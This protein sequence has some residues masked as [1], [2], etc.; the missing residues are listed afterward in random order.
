MSRT[1]NVDPITIDAADMRRL[2]LGLK[3]LAPKVRTRVRREIRQTGLQ[4]INEQKAILDGPLPAGVVKTGRALTTVRNPKT[5]KLRWAARNVYKDRDV[6]RGGRSTNLRADIKKGLKLRIV[7]G[8]TRQGIEFRTGGPKRE[9][10]N[11]AGVWNN[12]RF[13][14]PVFG[15]R[16]NWV[17]Q[18]GQ[19]FFHG[20]IY[21]GRN[22]VLGEI[23]AILK[24]EIEGI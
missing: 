24:R 6:K 4:V 2:L 20:P 12:K 9:G 23:E 3:D 7:I 18:H 11:M 8:K 14:H 19:P 10:S 16:D 17:D 21:R 5:G 1:R 22:K 15:N 13:R